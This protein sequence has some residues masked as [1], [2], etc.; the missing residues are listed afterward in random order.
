MQATRPR[1]MLPPLQFGLGVQLYHH[2]ASRFLIDTLHHLGFCCSYEEVHQFDRNK[3]RFYGANIP[4]LLTQF[5]QYAADNV[6]HKIR[7]L[8][9]LSTFHG[10]GM[11]A[12]IT[13][14]IT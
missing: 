14:G 12:T 6:D 8:D 1:A 9:G 3:A 13:P 2:F 4:E 10:M 11:I 5:V 7:T